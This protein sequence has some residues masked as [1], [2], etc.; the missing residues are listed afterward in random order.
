M[1]R[2]H[3]LPD[4]SQARLLQNTLRRCADD[5]EFTCNC[6]AKVFLVHRQLIFAT[7]V[8]RQNMGRAWSM[9]AIDARSGLGVRRNGCEEV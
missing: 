7:P 6:R 2:S 9:V 3:P 5:I 8:V 4:C 1:Q